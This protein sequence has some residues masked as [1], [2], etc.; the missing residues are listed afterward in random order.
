L[1]DVDAALREL[2]HAVTHLR[3][4]GVAVGTSVNGDYYD[5][6]RFRPFFA[7]V[8]RQG[9]P[10]F[11]HPDDVA[12][13]DRLVPFY[14]GR[15]IGNPHEAS[16]SLLRIILGGVLEDFP[17]LKL[18]FPMGGGSL[19]LLL[20]RVENGWAVRPEARARTPRRPTEYLRQCYFD[21]ILHSQAAFDYLVS[22]VPAEHVVMGSD[23]PWDM[24]PESP[25]EVID[26]SKAI[27]EDQRLGVLAGNVEQLIS[28]PGLARAGG[29][30]A[31]EATA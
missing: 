7:E 9:V 1:Q 18:C 17:G 23:Y 8:E 13:A 22:V 20:G 12:G 3:L 4:S 19:P 31:T 11:F 14:L 25:R 2:D 29:V 21:T 24:G 30:T 5:H 28:R 16:L 10:L 27:T 26:S 15:L 6:P